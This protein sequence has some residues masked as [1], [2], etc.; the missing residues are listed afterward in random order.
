M[1]I[2]QIRYIIVHYKLYIHTY[3]HKQIIIYHK[4]DTISN[5]LILNSL[6]LVHSTFPLVCGDVT[7][8]V[9]MS[10]GLW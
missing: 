9:V 7:R 8:F 5:I 10:R 2:Y 6:S 3:L 4:Y 1:N